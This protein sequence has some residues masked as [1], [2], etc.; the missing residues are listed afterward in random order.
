MLNAK[1]DAGSLLYLLSHFEC[2]G[3]TG[4]ML[5]EQRLPLPLTSTVKLSLFTHAPSSPLSL[6]PAYVDV[7]QTI[8]FILTM[9]ALFLDRPHCAGKIEYPFAEKYV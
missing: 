6:L 8:L 3:H 4:H 9:T 1:F 2:S 7:M 5:T